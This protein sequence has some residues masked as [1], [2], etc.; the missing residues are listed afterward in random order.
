[1]QS[2]LYMSVLERRMPNQGGKLYDFEV[3]YI[4]KWIK[5]GAKK[6]KITIKENDG[7]KDNDSAIDPTEPREE[8]C[9]TKDNDDTDIEVNG[10]MESDEPCDSQDVTDP[11]EP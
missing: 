11:F 2:S 3:E 10:A 6:E 7:L 9:G 8:P 5:Y 4:L 1:M